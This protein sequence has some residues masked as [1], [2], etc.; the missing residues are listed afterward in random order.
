MTR[1]IDAEHLLFHLQQVLAVK[2]RCRRQM[3]LDADAGHA[4]VVAGQRKQGHLA[5][6]VVLGVRLRG[7]DELADD[8]QFLGPVAGEAVHGAG[9][10]K[11][12][13]R[14]PVDGVHVQ[15]IHELKDVARH[16]ALARSEDLLYHR[17]AHV[18]YAQQTVA[19]LAVLRGE[20]LGA[21]VDVGLQGLDAH[22]L[23]VAD[24]DRYGLVVRGI[25]HQGGQELG[26]IVVFQPGRL[27]RYDSVGSCVGF[28]ERVGRETG[29]LV[30][31]GVGHFLVYAVADAAG[32][33]DG[34]VLVQFAVDEVLSFL[35][36]DVRLFLGHGAAHQVGA[37]VGVAAQFTDDVHD[38]LLIHDAAVRRSQDGFQFRAQI[39]DLLRM[40]LALYVGRD[41][42]HRTGPVQ[43]N[44]CDEIFQTGGAQVLHEPGHAAGFQLEDADRV[45]AGD[46]IV[47]ALFSVVDA[48]KVDVFSRIFFDEFQAFPDGC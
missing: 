13:E 10:D 43:R 1:Q 15:S 18:L 21:L 45:A 4:A 37:A 34:T 24:E 14:G 39:G 30:E 41:R 28:I 6:Q 32:H 2:V 29:H 31:D 7:I 12:L 25:G 19:D 42:V 40:L 38:L 48:V 11:A 22:V 44:T 16:V 5:F 20:V 47:D 26:R 9:L 8:R 33:V 23:G 36:H 17:F 46:Q 27:V 3:P 35:R